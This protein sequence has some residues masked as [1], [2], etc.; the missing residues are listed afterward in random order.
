MGIILPCELFP[1]IVLPVFKM[2]S[3][4][5]DMLMKKSVSGLVD[6]WEQSKSYC[7][8]WDE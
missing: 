2:M 3:S 4:P 6:N 5:S 1:I 7:S 8:H